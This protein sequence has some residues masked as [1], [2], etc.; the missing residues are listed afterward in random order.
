MAR[1]TIITRLT[2]DGAKRYVTIIGINGKQQWRT[3]DRKRDAENYLDDLSPEVRDGT[4]H[5]IKKA[6]FSEY[7]EHWQTAHL[8]PE[9][10]KPSTYNAYRSMIALH[11]LPAFKN[12]PMLAITPAEINSFSAKLLQQNGIGRKNKRSRKTVRNVLNLLGEILSKAVAEGYLKH[13]PME[14]VDRPRADKE[15]KGRALK[16]DEIQSILK[17]AAGIDRVMTA[18]A[19]ATGMRR[20][21][22][23][24]LDWQSIDFENNVIRIR[25]ALYWMFG[26]YHDRKE[27]EPGYVFTTPKS[28]KSIRD[29]D[30]SPELR[31]QLLELYMRSGRQ[32]LVFC[33]PAGTPLNPDNYVKR[34]FG[35][36]LRRAE[37]ERAQN[38][39]PAI[40]KIRWHDLRHTFGSL[41]LDQG[42]DLVYVSRQMGHSSPSVTADI[43]AHQIRARRPE[44]AAKTDAM[45]FGF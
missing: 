7:L 26:K 38:K 4:Y 18:T 37:T 41:K 31:K 17:S 30:M 23:F 29:I 35:E 1:G 19:I 44:A 14:G 8:L 10:F 33:S 25:R 13:S 2:K 24:G 16:P 12:Y 39:Q 9:Q 34:N 43:Y 15:Q 28:K 20:A 3:W 21:E 22:Q 36:V 6:T 11:L 32:G 42:E 45:I 5:E 27:G 40:G